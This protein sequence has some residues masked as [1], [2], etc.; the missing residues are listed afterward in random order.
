MH[1]CVRSLT[2]IAADNSLSP[3]RRKPLSVPILFK[4]FANKSLKYD[5]KHKFFLP[6]EDRF[7][8][9]IRKI[10]ANLPRPQYVT[11]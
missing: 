2:A 11:K 3:A 9:I 5:L 10:L 8:N 4:N 7:E 1:V 6:K